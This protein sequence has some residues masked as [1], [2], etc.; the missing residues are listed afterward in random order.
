VSEEKSMEIWAHENCFVWAPGV[1]LL[2]SKLMGLEE[3]VWDSL[4]TVRIGEGFLA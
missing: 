2:G 1:H 3:A 4:K